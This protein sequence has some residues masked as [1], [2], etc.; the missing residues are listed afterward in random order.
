MNK[1]ASV[2]EH[3]LAIAPS[4]VGSPDVVA[5]SLRG[6]NAS[7]SPIVSFHSF[8]DNDD[9]VSLLQIPFRRSP[10]GTSMEESEVLGRP[11]A[12]EAVDAGLRLFQSLPEITA[13]ANVVGHDGC[14]GMRKC[15]RVK[16]MCRRDTFR[17]RR[18]RAHGRNWTTVQDT[19]DLDDD[20]VECVHVEDVAARCACKVPLH[21]AHES[22]PLAT[23]CRRA[24]GNEIPFEA[25]SQELIR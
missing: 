23:I 4:D 15:G 1:L 3:D 9:D 25:F 21:Q 16:Y 7:H 13:F 24:G 22:L 6:D 10:F 11:Q 5:T 19:L 17:V 14:R 20:G 8:I 18:V 12:P 2:F